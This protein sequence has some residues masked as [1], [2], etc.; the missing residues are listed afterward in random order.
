[1]VK[2]PFSYTEHYNRSYP[3]VASFVAMHLFADDHDGVHVPPEE[4]S[5]YNA[6]NGSCDGHNGPA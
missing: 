3:L 1:M 4:Q 2:L 6:S 5:Q